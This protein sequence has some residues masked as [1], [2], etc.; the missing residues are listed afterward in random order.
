MIY[1]YILAYA[2]QDM[3]VLK[4]VID[5]YYHKGMNMDNKFAA[6]LSTI[7]GAVFV[8]GGLSLIFGALPFSNIQPLIPIILGAVAVVWGLRM[9]ALP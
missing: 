9:I 5:F 6:L 8:L 7:I 2:L 4:M 3:L 1:L